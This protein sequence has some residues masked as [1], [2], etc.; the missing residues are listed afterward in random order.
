MVEPIGYLH[1]KLPLQ[2]C[3]K[4]IDYF[5]YVDLTRL[6]VHISEVS[7]EIRILI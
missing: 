1:D 5:V 4:Y 6:P 7:E 2:M 3:G